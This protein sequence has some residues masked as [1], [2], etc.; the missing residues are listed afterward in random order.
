[1]IDRSGSTLRAESRPTL[2]STVTRPVAISTSLARREAT[3]GRGEDLLESLGRHRL[4]AR[5]VERRRGRGRRHRPGTADRHRFPA[6]LREPGGDVDVE[7]RQLVEAGQ[8]E[9]LEEFEPGAVQERPAGR[10]GPAELDDEPAMDQR[11]DRVVR[12]DAPD[13]LD[14]RLRDGLAVGDDRQRLERRRRQADGIGADV[15]GDERAAL[16]RRGQLDP[17]AVDEQADP[18]VAERDLQVAEP[19]VHGRP[20]HAGQG[21]DLAP[22]ERPLGDEQERLQGGLG[23]LDRGRLGGARRP[24]APAPASRRSRLGRD[25]QPF[26]GHANDSSDS[27]SGPSTGS[28]RSAGGRALLG[29]RRAGH[30]RAPR[31][32]L[33]D[34]D[35]AALH[36]LE[37]GQEGDRD[38]DPIADAAQQVLEHDDGRLAERGA[39]DRRPLG[40]RDQPGHD[41]GRRLG[42]RR[43]RGQ[44]R[45]APRRGS[46]GSRAG[47]RPGAPRP[48]RPPGRCRA[49]AGTA[50]SVGSPRRP[51][52]TRHRDGRGRRSA[53]RAA[54][55]RGRRPR[56]RAR[57]GRR[58]RPGAAASP[59][60]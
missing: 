8:P 23:Q 2:P 5:P 24:R 18:A 14:R 33:L 22:S 21:G 32:A 10:V 26:V 40:D 42:R 37:H 48:G 29:G 13:P 54:R 17:V 60:S 30:D 16:G 12:V 51:A 56:R 35:L 44:A 6:L 25:G 41:L 19:G 53:G 9:P 27:S 55:P 47:R 34:H 58:D 57:S 50:R 36:Q 7:R 45:R 31:L 59:G 11:P 15:A 20:V 49:R 38:D 46:A 28:G 39:D 52:A 43:D 3:P 4:V 1:M